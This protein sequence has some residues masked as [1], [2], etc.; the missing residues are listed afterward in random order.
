MKKL[1]LK[2]TGNAPLLMHSDI[3]AD[4]LNPQTI[5]LRK[6]TGNKKKTVADHLK[7]AELEWYAGLYLNDSDQVVIPANNVYRMLIEG[8]RRR[9]L[10]K[11]GEAAVFFDVQAFE[12]KHNGPKDLAELYAN[13]AF[14]DRRT[15][16]NKQVRVMRTRPVF[17][18]WSL[19]VGLTVD[20][21]EIDP[22]DIIRGFED[23]GRYVGLC[24][25]RPRHGRFDIE[26]VKGGRTHV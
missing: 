24:D 4:P 17:K 22:D 10:G 11:K 8:L 25:F 26:V 14:V 1:K 2:L 15:V 18:Q 13:K 5:E 21:D 20:D 16:G 23:A 19:T 3:V 6:Y 12:L 9:K 7:I